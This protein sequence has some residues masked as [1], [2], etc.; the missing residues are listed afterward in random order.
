MLE[1]RGSGA[2]MTTLVSI[3]A[4]LRWA[5]AGGV[6]VAGI[7]A[8]AH[9]ERARRLLGLAPQELAICPVLSVERN[10]A[11]LS[12]L[13]GL[14]GREP[15]ERVTVG[16]DVRTRGQASRPWSS[17]GSEARSR[18]STS[19]RGGPGPSRRQAPSA[20]CSGASAP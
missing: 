13:A 10:L 1:V 16:A 6:T 2:G 4:G 5:D 20:G 3:V 19:F 7:D 15:R 18:P 11:F 12:G 17:L 9:P 8:L 14:G